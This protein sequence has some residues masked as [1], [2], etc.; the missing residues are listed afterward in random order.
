MSEDATSNSSKPVDIMSRTIKENLNN[1]S[2]ISKGAIY[3][4]EKLL[5]EI[6]EKEK[7]LTPDTASDMFE[8]VHSLMLHIGDYTMNLNFLTMSVYQNTPPHQ[9]ETPPTTTD[10]VR[11]G[12]DYVSDFIHDR[13]EYHYQQII[14]TVIHDVENEHEIVTK[15]IKSVE[16][17]RY[18]DMHRAL[19]FVQRWLEAIHARFSLIQSG[20][21]HANE[22]PPIQRT[23]SM[24]N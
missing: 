20:L 24:Y 7:L 22:N 5:E 9:R 3:D 11:I 15:T 13:Q 21:E 6:S 10:L 17:K 16:K 19:V 14:A 2:D 4:I 18:V 23:M 12:Y 1:R 8:D